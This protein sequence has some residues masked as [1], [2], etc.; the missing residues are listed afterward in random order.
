[1]I[2]PP[3]VIEIVNSITSSFLITYTWCDQVDLAGKN[4]RCYVKNKAHA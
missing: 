3:S 4:K 2:E 1:M